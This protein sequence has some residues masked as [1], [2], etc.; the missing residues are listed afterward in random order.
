[1]AVS[2]ILIATDRA[3]WSRRP[4]ALEIWDDR[5]SLIEYHIEQLQAAG[6]VDI[7]VVLG[8]GA[9]EVIPLVARDNVEPIVNALWQ[10]DPASSLRA[11]AAAVVRGAAA[12]V[13][14]DIAEPRPAG[15]L[16]T[17][18]DAHEGA[19]V[20][21]PVFAG[22]RGAPIVAGEHALALLR[23]T[24]RNAR[25]LAALEGIEDAVREVAVESDVVL[26]RIDSSDAYERV[27]QRL[28]AG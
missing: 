9:E 4:L 25:A 6:V 23:N 20:T 3:P 18:L 26:L 28:G 11:G 16:R 27:R 21:A 22:L 15:V 13:V 19:E 17:L 24:R 2:G 8:D 14:I 10:S 5:R 12:A 7:E 1:M